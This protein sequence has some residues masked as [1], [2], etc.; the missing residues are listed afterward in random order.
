[1]KG[2]VAFDSVYGNTRQVAEALKDEL[3][4]AG[5]TVV[6]LNV[7]ETREVPSEGDFLFVGSPTRFGKM[8]SRSKR[9]VKKLDAES[10]RSKPIVVFDTHMPYPD[11]PE[12]KRKSSKWINPGAAGRLTELAAGRGMNVRGPPLRCLVTD[13]KGPLAEGQL[14]RARDYARQFATSLGK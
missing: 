4:K 11:E 6:L 14:E 12:E 13:M 7:K 5:H 8:T 3:E 10:W 2:V 9:L 1:M